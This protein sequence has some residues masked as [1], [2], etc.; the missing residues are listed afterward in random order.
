MNKFFSILAAA[1]IFAFGANANAI[2]IIDSVNGIDL[3]ISDPIPVGTDVLDPGLV[4]VTLSAVA[5]D[6]ATIITAFSGSIGNNGALHHEQFAGG[7][8]FFDPVTTPTGATAADSSVDS[9]FLTSVGAAVNPPAEDAGA[10]TGGTPSGEPGDF[11]L[12]GGFVGFGPALAGDFAFGGDSFGQSVDLAQLVVQFGT[13]V[14]YNVLTIG[15]SEVQRGAEFGDGSFLVGIP[16]PST[17]I[18]AGLALV[19]FVARRK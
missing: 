4:Q 1:A 11:M 17:A 15:A 18:L 6:P 8:P 19:G 12:A 9:H 7:P 14:D 10:D 5:S 16:E 2:T 3:V 13:V